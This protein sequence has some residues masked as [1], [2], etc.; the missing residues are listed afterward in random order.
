[1]QYYL[2]FRFMATFALLVGPTRMVGRDL[3][4]IA[5]ARFMT[6]KARGA[7]DVVSRG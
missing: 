1:M 3:F 7:P 4:G 5:Y 6:G 2:L